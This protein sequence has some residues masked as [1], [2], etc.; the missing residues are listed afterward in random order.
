M[1]Y[2]DN[3]F[4]DNK[5]TVGVNRTGCFFRCNYSVSKDS[6]GFSVLCKSK[7][8]TIQIISEFQYGS[9]ISSRNYIKDAYFFR[10]KRNRGSDI[11]YLKNLLAGLGKNDEIIVSH[12]TITTALHICAY[13]GAKNIIICGHDGGT[14]NGETSIHNYYKDINPEQG[15]IESYVNWVKNMPEQTILVRR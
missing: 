9:Q 3:S 4:F 6:K 15:S 12:S 5:I 1:N 8:P 2:I 13:L 11:F 14:I 10:H 7:Y